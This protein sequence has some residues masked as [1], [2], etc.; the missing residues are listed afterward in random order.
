MEDK[1]LKKLHVTFDDGKELVGVDVFIYVWKEMPG[2][3]WLG[4]FTDLPVI[5]QL[6]KCVYAVLAFI[7][8]WRFK[9]FSKA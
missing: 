6:A 8:F 4:I 7:L 1:Y 2:Y 9:L 5:K 3:K